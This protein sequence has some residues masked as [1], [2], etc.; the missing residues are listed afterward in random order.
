M[1]AET[2]N[3]EITEIDPPTVRFWPEVGIGGYG[4][5][6]QPQLSDRIPFH[7]CPSMKAN[8]FGSPP[9]RVHALRHAEG[10]LIGYLYRGHVIE[11]YEGWWSTTNFELLERFK[12][13]RNCVAAIDESMERF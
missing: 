11:L 1:D 4:N 3:N 7:R 5:K 9:Y 12:R 6:N 10:W 13:L 2:K 8:G